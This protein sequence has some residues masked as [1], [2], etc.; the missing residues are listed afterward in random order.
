MQ[1]SALNDWV[2]GSV[3]VQVGNN[4]H[5][6][7]AKK[8][9]VCDLKNSIL[10]TYHIARPLCSAFIVIER[11]ENVFDE[12]FAGFRQPEAAVPAIEEPHTNL[13]FDVVDSAAQ[14]GLCH[15]QAGGR[16]RQTPF[17]RHHNGALQIVDC[18]VILHV[19]P[20]NHN[21]INLELSA[22]ELLMLTCIQL[23]SV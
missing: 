4:C 8:R 17:L 22:T 12:D 9:R 14:G 10:T 16:A 20:E 13:A 2:V 5:Q 11:L 7:R 15:V 21:E 6:L 3:E 19:A 1:A 23:M 18:D